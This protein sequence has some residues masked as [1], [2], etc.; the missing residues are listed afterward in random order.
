MR[1]ALLF[2]LILGLVVVAQA[3]TV[4]Q[5]PVKP[6]ASLIDIRAL[7]T[8]ISEQLKTRG[9]VG[10]SVALMQDG[11]IILAKGYGQASLKS[12]AAATP[13][14]SFAIGSITKQFTC[15]C[16]LKLAEDGKLSVEDKVAKYYPNLTRANDITLLDLM[17]HVSGYPDYYPLDFVDRRMLKA[18]APDEL[19]R[20]YAGGNLDFE[21]G[22][23]Y[24][25]SNTGF[26]LLGR[27]AEKVSG[28]P[29][30]LFLKRQILDPLGMRLTYFEPELT[31][32]GLATGYTMFALS[33][34]EEAT[35]EAKGWISAAG[36][37]YSTASDL[38]AWDL[39]LVSGKL[40]KPESYDLMTRP[41][42]LTSG[43]A[44][45]Y[46][47]GLS[48]GLRNGRT[49]LS[50]NGAVSGFNALNAVV[51]TTK[52]AVVLLSNLEDSNAVN[53]IYSKLFSAL[54]SVD[55]P[56]LPKIAGPTVPEVHKKMFLSLQAGRVDRALLGEEFSWYLNDARIS[57]ASARLKS[58]GEP[59]KVEIESVSERGGMEVSRTRIVCV[60]GVL[61]GLMY[62]T[63]DGQVQQFFV[64]KE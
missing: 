40:L 38:A 45:G 63:P 7:D 49:I 15:A 31:Q 16:I 57:S 56:Y 64:A 33:G 17:N 2:I 25:Y 43:R 62:R 61:K 35:P 8:Y 24:S 41:R 60:Y 51:P 58:Y 14:T 29:F 48:V 46:G 18:I 11:K 12:G 36:A 53:A 32:A 52:S 34:P 42:L 44:S 23:Q 1:K 37:L 13:E 27:I 21:P 19:L 55:A 3:S 39:A 59:V 50:H 9:L 22:S 20:Q 54:L 10:L 4:Q 28:Q 6:T 26:V 5:T 30:G 47:C